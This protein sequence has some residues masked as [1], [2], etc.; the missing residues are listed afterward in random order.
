VDLRAFT[1]N[2]SLAAA[3]QSAKLLEQVNAF[4]AYKDGY[5]FQLSD[6]ESDLTGNEYPVDLTWAI[7]YQRDCKRAMEDRANY[8][9]VSNHSE[10]RDSQIGGYVC[11]CREGFDGNPYVVN[12]CAGEAEAS[13]YDF[14]QPKANCA[15][16]CGNV[17]FAFPFGTEVG[18]FA[19]LQLY[20]TCSNPRSSAPFL[21]MSDGSV[22]TSISI[23]EGI[24]NVLKPSDPSHFV[25]T[26]LY[27]F[28]EEWGVVKWAVDSTTCKNA[29]AIK[30]GY[31]CFS[32]NSD[33][34]DV[35]DDKTYRE[36]GYRCKCSRGFQ[37]NPYLKDGCTDINE[38]LQPDKYICNGICQNTFGSYTCTHCP[39]GTD[40]NANTR[41]CRPA[42]IILGV[43]IGLSSGGTI[44]FVDAIF[45]V[46]T[47][48]WKRSVQKRLR[49][50]FFRK[51][52]GIL[53]EQLIS[54]DQN[55]SDGMEIFSLEELEKATNNFDHARVVGRGGYGTV[56]K[57]ILTD[58]R[59]VAIKRSMLEAST[60][61]EQ[62]INEVSI[63]LQINHSRE[64][65]WVLP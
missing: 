42:T 33:C 23:D 61:I 62:F 37:G 13:V 60:E 22:V 36:V 57:G 38:C 44:L 19:N 58:Q 26:P 4:I 55:A 52:K 47:R 32:N 54:S 43:S 7:P 39:H 3:G 20:L 31:R 16:S 8:A 17:S 18:C 10:C 45:V 63:L 48:K 12:G 14:V 34:V 64:A 56:Y 29:T 53:L 40:F 50:R 11:Y 25:E 49:K 41:K 21:Q 6:L 46:L 65:P 24:L 51:N 35:R 9:R 1:L 27:A 28:S 30:K 5:S 59:V 2:I 15:T